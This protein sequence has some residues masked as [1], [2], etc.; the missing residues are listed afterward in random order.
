MQV[1]DRFEK[2]AFGRGNARC[3][4]YEDLRGGSLGSLQG[5]ELSWMNNLWIIYEQLSWMNYPYNQGFFH[6]FWEIAW[7]GSEI[8]FVP[9]NQCRDQLWCEPGGGSES[10]GDDEWVITYIYIPSLGLISIHAERPLLEFWLLVIFNHVTVLMDIHTCVIS[11]VWCMLTYNTQ[12][13]CILNILQTW[14]N[15]SCDASSFW[16]STTG[17][18]VVMPPGEMPPVVM[19]QVIF[20]YPLVN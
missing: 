1:A 7:A 17:D 10:T 18:Q 19:P 11:Y 8:Y 12:T 6:T 2:G 13:Y 20:F 4:S 14:E 5:L 15:I 3:A 9:V 16:S